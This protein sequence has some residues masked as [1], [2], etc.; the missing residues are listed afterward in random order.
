M[1]CR[2]AL[3]AVGELRP[4]LL[5]TYAGG[6]H[7]IVHAEMV[8]LVA[9]VATD[10]AVRGQLWIEEEL[11]TEGH[12]LQCVRTGGMLRLVGKWVE[13]G[14]GLFTQLLVAAQISATVFGTRRQL[15]GGLIAGRTNCEQNHNRVFHYRK[16]IQPKFDHA[17]K[18]LT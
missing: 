8:Q 18:S 3:Y 6:C 10:G 11:L 7:L 16:G 17:V 5:P 2:A 4:P 15:G 12:F 13:E 14:Q 9:G 1:L